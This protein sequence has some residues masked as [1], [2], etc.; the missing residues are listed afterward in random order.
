MDFFNYYDGSLHCESVTARDIASAVG[1]P[2]YVYSRAT[3]LLA[4][5]GSMIWTGSLSLA[6]LDA[7]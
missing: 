7:L 5:I 3:L 1:T 6:T 2:C 4:L